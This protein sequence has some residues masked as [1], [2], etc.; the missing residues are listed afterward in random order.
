M[1]VH[2]RCDAGE[3]LKIYIFEMKLVRDILLL[4]CCAAGRR[5]NPLFAHFSHAA[6]KELKFSLRCAARR[7]VAMAN[8]Q[9]AHKMRELPIYFNSHKVHQYY[10]NSRS[11]CR[12]KAAVLFARIYKPY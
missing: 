5:W 1:C 2:K 7:A 6:K 9:S 4:L 12:I 3:R 11:F 10:Y 8:K